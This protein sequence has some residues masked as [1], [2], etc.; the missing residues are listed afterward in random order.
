[1]TDTFDRTRRDFLTV[2][3][4]GGAAATVEVAATAGAQVDVSRQ[5]VDGVITKEQI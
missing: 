5:T 4:V 2:A 3:T 1:M